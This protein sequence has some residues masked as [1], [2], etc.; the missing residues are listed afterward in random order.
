[1]DQV[2][3]TMCLSL[4]SGIRDRQTQWCTKRHH[5]YHGHILRKKEETKTKIYSTGNLLCA[6]SLIGVCGNHIQTGQSK[7]VHSHLMCQ[8]I[9]TQPHLVKGDC[10]HLSQGTTYDEAK[11]YKA[12]SIND[13]VLLEV[14]LMSRKSK[15]RQTVVPFHLLGLDGLEQAPSFSGVG[16]LSATGHLD[17]RFTRLNFGD[18][19]KSILTIHYQVEP[20]SVLCSLF[21]SREYA[22]RM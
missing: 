14:C 13:Y 22:L 8:E 11:A 10:V 4:Q 20:D 5:I 1:M 18:Y 6:F 16:N 2:E 3:E 9:V 12:T 19:P 15:D 7:E 21:H 17:L